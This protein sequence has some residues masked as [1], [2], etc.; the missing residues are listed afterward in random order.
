MVPQSSQ[1]STGLAIGLQGTPL[2]LIP[3]GQS[4]LPSDADAWKQ[5]IQTLAPVHEPFG[6]SDS[7]S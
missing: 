5:R 4:G 1:R 6:F 7:Q 2:S 3:N